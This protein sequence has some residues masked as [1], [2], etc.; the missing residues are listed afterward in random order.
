MA[1]RKAKRPRP[2]R[3]QTYHAYKSR[4]AAIEQLAA[5]L[6][7]PKLFDYLP[8]EARTLLKTTGSLP[9][10]VEAS[11]AFT[12]DSDHSQIIQ[13]IKNEITKKSIGLDSTNIECSLNHFFSTGQT[14]YS[15]LIAY[16]CKD[17][18][19]TAYHELS[20]R[21]EAIFSQENIDEANK[22]LGRAIVSILFGFS[23]FDQR[24][25]WPEYIHSNRGAA[26]TQYTIVIH[27]EAPV[28][29]QVTVNGQSRRAY[30]C[31]AYI[32]GD[33][34]EWAEWAPKSVPNTPD[35]NTKPVYVQSHALRRFEERFGFPE[36]V[37]YGIV[38][39]HES[40]RSPNLVKHNGGTEWLVEYKMDSK[41]LGY[42]VASVEKDIVLVKTFLFLTMRGTPE[43][44]KIRTATKTHPRFVE[45]MKLDDLKSYIS[46]DL[47]LDS[48][49]RSIFTQ[50]GCGHLFDLGDQL[51]DGHYD[52]G[53]AE[54]VRRYLGMK[55]G[56]RH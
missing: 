29:R 23:R 12:G 42:L 37:N 51:N 39:I 16:P 44:L 47:R 46:S 30:L 24:L 15:M 9:L 4:N 3:S 28:E 8:R 52:I 18:R 36:Y 7:T 45:I 19:K 14:L 32:G 56:I 55:L 6:G 53:R 34:V 54:S 21:M 5:E 31:G 17:T 26:F 25:L 22:C 35:N 2:V 33:Q 27:R 20:E 49:L 1:R 11:P 48:Q 40:L 43:E 50:C 41:R 13:D 10:R 38:W